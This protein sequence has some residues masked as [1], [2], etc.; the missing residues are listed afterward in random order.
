MHSQR[1]DTRYTSTDRIQADDADRLVVTKVNVN[2]LNQQEET[3]S[4]YSILLG[5]AVCYQSIQG[6][7][8]KFMQR[9]F[10][11]I[12]TASQTISLNYAFHIEWPDEGAKNERDAFMQTARR[13]EAIM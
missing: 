12:I 5:F 13:L 3:K 10:L 8:A 2:D 7:C 6:F 9:F 4:T 1:N 11:F